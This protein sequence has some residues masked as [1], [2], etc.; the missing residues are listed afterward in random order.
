M[1][2]IADLI[3]II[4]A[5]MAAANETSERALSY[6]VFNDTK[7][8]SH[9]REGRDITVTRFNMA[10]RWFSDNWP[11]GEDRPLPLQRYGLGNS[12]AAA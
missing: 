10:M 8:I 2:Q 7:K 3:A 6:R 5:Y 9:L 4:D 11:D 1:T 12:E